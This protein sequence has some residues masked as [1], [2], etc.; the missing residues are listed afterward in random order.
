LAPAHKNFW[1]RT[2]RERERERERLFASL[3]RMHSAWIS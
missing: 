1:L 2:C 3:V